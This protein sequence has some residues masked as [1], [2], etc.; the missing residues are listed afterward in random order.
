MDENDSFFSLT[1][2]PTHAPTELELEM[3]NT[4][5]ARIDAQ[6]EML[7]ARPQVLNDF[8]EVATY[9]GGE[10]GI[11]YEVDNILEVSRAPLH[12]S[13]PKGVNSTLVLKC[14]QTLRLDYVRIQT[15]AHVNFALR[16]GV[17]W[18]FAPEHGNPQK[19][20][21]A[22]THRDMFRNCT[23]AEDF[24]RICDQVAAIRRE[25]KISAANSEKCEAS[26]VS[27]TS[28]A[29]DAAEKNAHTTTNAPVDGATIDGDFDEKPG[30]FPD[31]FYF[32]T[33]PVTFA[34]TIALRNRNR[35]DDIETYIRGVF[36][37]I[38]VNGDGELSMDELVPPLIKMGYSARYARKIIR[39]AD[40]D[41]NG[42]IDADEFT[43]H[44]STL[45]ITSDEGTCDTQFIEL[46]F[47]AVHDRNKRQQ[48]AHASLSKTPMVSS[49]KSLVQQIA[50]AGYEVD[51][52]AGPDIVDTTQADSSVAADQESD[53]SPR[54]STGRST[55]R[56]SKG[57]RRRRHAKVPHLHCSY[58]CFCGHTRDKAPREPDPAPL[59]DHEL[60]KPRHLRRPFVNVAPPKMAPMPAPGPQ[61]LPTLNLFDNDFMPHL[62]RSPCVIVYTANADQMISNIARRTVALIAKEFG[63]PSYP[64]QEMHHASEQEVSKD[65]LFF[66]VASCSRCFLFCRS[67]MEHKR[68]A[69]L[70]FFPKT[71]SFSTSTTPIPWRRLWPECSRF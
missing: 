61:V 5:Q 50:E 49:D 65:H 57:K 63:D 36:A 28:A 21:G 67:W 41:G 44:M 9:N 55:L 40:D 46:L 30:E 66:E 14:T 19:H 37:E 22:L 53:M 18:L 13:G 69:N 48:Q 32:E 51:G 42:V 43:A 31:C 23:S 11:G 68:I 24:D 38:D 26:S 45:N 34:T 54:P 39:D 16:S 27:T 59:F 10:A 25:T 15:S 52:G 1:T 2:E 20:N 33:D 29:A 58:M 62:N 35:I 70:D 64:R 6:M 60:Y 12:R 8:L 47:T 56:S 17:V 4:V 3:Q 71:S 7:Q